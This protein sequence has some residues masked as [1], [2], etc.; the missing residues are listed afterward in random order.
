MLV[1]TVHDE[2]VCYRVRMSWLLPTPLL[3]L[4]ALLRR[5]TST[6]RL[7]AAA[8]VTALAVIALVW[9]VW[10]ALWLVEQRW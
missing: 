9:L 1:G 3:P 8:F 4:V 10:V 5:P 7:V 2:T 6:P